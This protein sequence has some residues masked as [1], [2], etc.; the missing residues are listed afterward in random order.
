M[1][2]IFMLAAALLFMTNFSM[3]AQAPAD[4]V[5]YW[6]IGGDASLTF[7]QTALV[8]W[9][10]GGVNSFSLNGLVNFHA[11][12]QKNKLLWTNNLIMAYGMYKEKDDD[13]S[14]S[15]DKIDFTSNFG[16]EMRKN[17]YYSVTAGFKSQFDKGFPE[18]QDTLYNSNWLAPAYA[19]LGLGL[20]YQPNENLQLIIAPATY[21]MTIVNN[22]RLADA[23][24]Y[25]LDGAEFEA[26]NDSTMVLVKHGPK[27]R[28]EF[29]FDLKFMWKITIVKNVDFQTNL[30]LYSNY[31][32]DPQNIDV[33][34]DNYFNFTINNWL[35]AQL[36]TS[37]IYDHDIDIADSDGNRGPRT[38][39]K[40]TFGLGLAYKFGYQKE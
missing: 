34:W 33:Y 5:K 18:D 20:T 23:G 11:D 28:H 36:T 12:Y 6:K 8:N 24:E 22:V 15:D 16:Y 4:T 29:G 30:E 19:T 32:E 38:Q 27:L 21:R 25:G 13:R 14:K 39:F 37:L 7:G 9:S 10:A 17:W 26:I 31:L 2:R 1:K 40:Q 3:N 35:S